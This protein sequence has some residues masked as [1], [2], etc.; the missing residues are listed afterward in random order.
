[1]IDSNEL[2]VCETCKCFENTKAI[3]ILAKGRNEHIVQP[4]VVCANCGGKLAVI[5]NIERKIDKN[6]VQ[7]SKCN[8]KMLIEASLCGINVF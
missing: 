6:D 4:K 8:T 3:L 7:C 1:M 2:S 5:K